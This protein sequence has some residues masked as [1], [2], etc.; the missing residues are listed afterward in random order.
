MDFGKLTANLNSEEFQRYLKYYETFHIDRKKCIKNKKCNDIY[1]ETPTQL[2]VVKGGKNKIVKKPTYVFIDSRID[3]LKKE[4][5]DLE[6]EI[7]NFRFIVE[8]NTTKKIAEAFTKVKEDYLSKKNELEEIKAYLLQ[9]KGGPEAKDRLIEINSSIMEQENQKRALFFEI[10]RETDPEKKKEKIR[11]YLDNRE[12]NKLKREK[13]EMGKLSHINYLVTD[14]PQF[15]KATKSPSTSGPSSGGEKPK[16]KKT[17]KRCPPG[18]RRN[19]ETGNC[20][21]K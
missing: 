8:S 4:M 21:P 6:R 9:S 13:S 7:R 14:L 19:K 20:E 18:E 10:Q 16:K 2:K 3:E 1:E 11:E 12:L 17:I 15:N 5:N